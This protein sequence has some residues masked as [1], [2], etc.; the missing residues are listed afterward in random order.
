[1]PLSHQIYS[2]VFNFL[3]GIF[4]SLCLN[5]H[6]NYA[7]KKRLRIKTIL[8]FL[9]ILINT[10]LYFI[11]IRIINSGILHIYYIITFL[12]GVYVAKFLKKFIAKFFNV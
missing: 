7:S 1:M 8:D 10:M 4:F 11:I 5:F 9:F 12:I 6:Y 3:Y 2:L